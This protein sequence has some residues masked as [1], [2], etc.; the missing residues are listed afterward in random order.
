[1][2]QRSAGDFKI[3]QA[4]RPLL[5]CNTNGEWAFSGTGFFI[6]H[7]G[8]PIL[9]TANHVALDEPVWICKDPPVGG[10]FSLEEI[11]APTKRLCS[12]GTDIALYDPLEFSPGVTLRLCAAPPPGNYLVGSYEYV[13]LLVD[14]ERSLFNSGPSTRIGN[15]GRLVNDDRYPGDSL[16]LS[17][18]A[19]NGA[20]GAPVVVLQGPDKHKVTGVLIANVQ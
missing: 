3:G 13:R 17:Y 9:V 2:R 18:P 14:R 6:E 20:S 19:L 11:L 5:T 10:Q 12:R 15:V 1:M 16:E 7:D 8:R 4:V